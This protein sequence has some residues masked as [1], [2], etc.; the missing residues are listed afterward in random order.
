MEGGRRFVARD[1]ARNPTPDKRK[2]NLSDGPN[3]I[4][5]SCTYSGSTDC[6]QRWVHMNPAPETSSSSLTNNTAASEQSYMPTPKATIPSK[7]LLPRRDISVNCK[8][9]HCLH[10]TV[11]QENLPPGHPGGSVF[12]LVPFSSLDCRFFTLPAEVKTGRVAPH[13]ATHESDLRCS[14]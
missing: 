12:C 2:V 3:Q 11:V 5:F 6:G 14:S 4:S 9:V 10:V 1:R 13:A 8:H 7:P